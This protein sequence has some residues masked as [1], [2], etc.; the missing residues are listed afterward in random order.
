MS[1][2]TPAHTTLS[3]MAVLVDDP[4]W[5][6]HGTLW[7]HLVSDESLEELHGF[8][9]SA[10]IPRRVFQGDHYDVPL[11]RIDELVALGAQRVGARELVK[12]LIASGL[13]IR[14]RDRKR[15]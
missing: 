15:L 6:A 14:P 9:A 11:E 13:R 12:R 4:I 5:P 10:G 8:A 7:A 1:A 3:H 2:C